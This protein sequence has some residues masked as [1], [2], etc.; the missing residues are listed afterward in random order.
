MCFVVLGLLGFAIVSE[1]LPV[2]LAF[3]LPALVGLAAVLLLVQRGRTRLASAMLVTLFWVIFAVACWMFD[4][5]RSASMG[6]FLLVVLAAG[7]LISSRAAFLVALLSAAAG[8]FM[9]AADAT[10]LLPEPVLPLTNGF[11]W[12]SW[13]MYFGMAA[14]LLHVTVRRLFVALGR[15]RDNE[16]ALQRAMEQLRD[17]TVSKEYVEDIIRQMAD[18]VFVLDRAGNVRSAN[19]AALAMLR[20][21]ERDL[22][23]RSHDALMEGVADLTLKRQE[24][25]EAVFLDADGNRV[26][27]ALSVATVRDAS[28]EPDGAVCIARDISAQA[29]LERALREASEN[30]E[31]A[32]KAKSDFLANMSHELR[33]PLNA[34]IGYTELLLD[35]SE[36]SLETSDDLQRI[37]TAGSGLLGLIKDILDLSKIEAGRMAPDIGEVSLA[38]L[39]D[40][41]RGAVTPLLNGRKNHLET[42]IAP[43]LSVLHTDRLRLRQILLNLLSNAAKFTEEGKITLEIEDRGDAVALVVRDTGIGMS[44]EQLQRVFDAFTQADNTTTRRYGGT[45]LGLTISQHLCE[46]LGGRLEVTSEEGVGTAFTAVVRRDL[47]GEPEPLGVR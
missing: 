43:T 32:S 47:R 37:H 34:I 36:L 21:T 31:A 19:K 33:T 26:P 35:D 5:V 38:P 41:V 24:R 8:L 23:G 1:N 15:A 6:G 44:A 18:A 14:V 7:L 12:V 13:A 29:A 2:S 22:V 3:H 20:Y 10:G 30:A 40:E 16:M 4:G 27:V 46:L 28:G 39:I 42:T 11:K 45:G 25:K 17:T 9:V